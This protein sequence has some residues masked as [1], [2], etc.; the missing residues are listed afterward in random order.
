MRITRIDTI[1]VM[2]DNS[3]S[4]GGPPQWSARTQ[5]VVDEPLPSGTALD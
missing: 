2:F 1:R 5:P 4:S 3:Y